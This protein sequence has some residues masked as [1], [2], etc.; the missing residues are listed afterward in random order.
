MI[1]R[2]LDSIN[3]NTNEIQSNYEYLAQIEAK[4]DKLSDKM[5][6]INMQ[7]NPDFFSQGFD[8]IELSKREQELFL[9][10]YTE[11]D[12]ISIIN[13]ARKL[14][15]TFEMCEVMLSRI[16]SKGIPV[17]RQRVD[18]NVFVSLDYMFKDLQ[19]RKNFLKIDTTVSQMIG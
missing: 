4:V 17:V 1:L 2:N 10:I 9:G 18:G 11:E 12:R 6:D 3:Q 8:K 7:L 5:D 19:A 16:M 13:L 15:L 14:G